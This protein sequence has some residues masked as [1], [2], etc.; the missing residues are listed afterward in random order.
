[1]CDLSVM[2]VCDAGNFCEEV[3]KVTAF[4]AIEKTKLEVQSVNLRAS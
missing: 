1:M 4:K 3:T 2:R